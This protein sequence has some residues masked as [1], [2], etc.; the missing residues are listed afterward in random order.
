MDKEY[1]ADQSGDNAVGAFIAEKLGCFQ[2][3]LSFFF[4]TFSFCWAIRKSRTT[5][6]EMVLGADA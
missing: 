2:L 3:S 6:A 1:R 5:H 4:V